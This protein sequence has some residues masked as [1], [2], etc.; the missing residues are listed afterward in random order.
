[1]AVGDGLAALEGKIAV[2]LEHCDAR[3][4]QLGT[5]TSIS[6]QVFVYSSE[7]DS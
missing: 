4:N 5:Y 7:N 3:R 2:K 1:L 6:N